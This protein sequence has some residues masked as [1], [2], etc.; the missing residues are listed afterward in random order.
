MNQTI[1]ISGSKF[2][3]MFSLA[4]ASL[5]DGKSKIND[6]L[7]ND[8][9]I[10]LINALEKIGVDTD[11]SYDKDAEKNEIKIIGSNGNIAPY[12][13]EIYLQNSGTA[14]RLMMCI[15][16]LGRGIYFLSGDARLKERQITDEI[17]TLSEIG[18][19]MKAKNNMYPPVLIDA[20]GFHS[21]KIKIEKNINMK[22][23]AA[24]LI[25][26]PYG[27]TDLEIETAVE[28]P[29]T[30]IV[31]IT[32]EAMKTFG[33]QVSHDGYKYFKV[34]NKKKYVSRDDITI[35]PD[36][37]IAS[38]F[39][40]I[41][42]ITC[43][44]I[45]IDGINYFNTKQNDVKFVDIL[46]QMGCYVAKGENFIEVYKNKNATLKG[47]EVDMTTMTNLTQLL[48][49]VALQADTPTII[50]GVK[51]IRHKKV[52]RIA[53]ITSE[54]ATI[55]AVIEDIDENTVK[56]IPSEKYNGNV[57]DTYNDYRTTMALSLA[58][59]FIDDI[60]IMDAQSVFKIYP[61]FFKTLEKL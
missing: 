50:K 16:N 55:G 42:A 3:S 29:D 17:D 4:I 19:S 11:F 6:M 58:G 43:G 49:V 26:A 60:S 61:D 10:T 14:L 39:F 22:L 23:L 53:A 21:R 12:L 51:S 41:A 8:D 46:Q 25:T 31:D 36:A 35:E 2:L 59:T 20:K 57:L 18:M 47:V 32:M 13:G 40:A 7:I 28:I 9:L 15:A 30:S 37:T 34:E 48:A 24:L 52:D 54:F 5:A 45:R 33:V 44:R 38:Y 56:V 1:K 27:E